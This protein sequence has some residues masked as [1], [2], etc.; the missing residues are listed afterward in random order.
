VLAGAIVCF[1]Y[2][3]LGLALVLVFIGVKMLVARWLAVPTLAT[4][5][6]VAGIF[7]LAIAASVAAGSFERRAKRLACT[8]K[9]S[10][11]QELR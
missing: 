3:K 1:C 6:V 10:S 4:L 8:A 2:L 7:A 5:T 11:V 9:P